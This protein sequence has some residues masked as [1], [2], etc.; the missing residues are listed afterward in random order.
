M[1]DSGNARK[2][3]EA[4]ERGRARGL[5]DALARDRA[6]LEKIRETN[7]TTYELYGPAVQTLHNL[8]SR[9]RLGA[10]AEGRA[11]LRSAI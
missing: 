11:C 6:D 3:V 9:E 4:L 2:A 7:P 5:G 10:S 1:K 8:E